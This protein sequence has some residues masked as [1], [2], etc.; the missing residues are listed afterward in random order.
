M[1]ETYYSVA[2]WVLDTIGP[3]AAS[4]YVARMVEPGANTIRGRDFWLAVQKEIR[5]RLEDADSV[6]E[7]GN[8][9]RSFEKSK[10]G[11]RKTT[12]TLGDL[13][14]NDSTEKS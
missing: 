1:T 2:N 5:S 4:P 3:V 6:D 13:P 10:G 9:A 11:K 7:L 8:W 12:R 14:A